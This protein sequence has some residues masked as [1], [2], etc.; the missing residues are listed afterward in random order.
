MYY[1]VHY[2][3][4]GSSIFQTHLNLLCPRIFFQNKDFISFSHYYKLSILLLLHNKVVF[5]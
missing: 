1:F 3:K 4:F 5:I 2:V